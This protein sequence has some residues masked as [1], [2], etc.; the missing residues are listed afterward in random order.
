VANALYPSK[1]NNMK[2]LTRI[3]TPVAADE[4]LYRVPVEIQIP[5]E[6]LTLVPQGEDIYSGGFDIYVVVANKDGDLSDVARK[7]HQIHVPTVDL[8]KTRGKFY[9]YSVD[10]LMEKG[11]N[12]IS[13]GVSDAISNVTGFARDQV[14]A[15]NL[16]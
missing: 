5:M 12:K 6:S 14:I 11:L 4:D 7:T 13:V 10:L 15:K 8:K 9:T 3:G 16:Q 2:I 1:A